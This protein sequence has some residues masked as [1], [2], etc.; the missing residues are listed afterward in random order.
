MR[1][2][3]YVFSVCLDFLDKTACGI[4]FLT[5]LGILI[6]LDF[7]AIN[8]DQ[9]DD[10]IIIAY[11]C[12]KYLMLFVAVLTLLFLVKKRYPQIMHI[13][14]V[15]WFVLFISAPYLLHHIPS[16]SRIYDNV[17]YDRIFK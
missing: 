6:N 15:L 5:A 17:T 12:L 2:L 1:K 7:F 13:E 16:V 8:I 3:Q 11:K 10:E 14:A 4:L 9:Y